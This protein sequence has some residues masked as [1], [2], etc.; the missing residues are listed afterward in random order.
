MAANRGRLARPPRRWLA[1]VIAGGLAVAA[2]LPFV[3]LSGSGHTTYYVSRDGDDRGGRSW[4]HA[5]NELD[6]IRW[7][8]VRPGDVVTIDG[9]SVA[10]P[11]DA[12]PQAGLD[13]PGARPTCGMVYRTPLVV[14]AS[15]RLGAPV[16]VALSTDP[17]H[18]GTAVV[19][20]GRTTPLPYCNQETYDQSGTELPAGIAI[21][22]RMHVVIDGR[23]RSG[24]VV[25]GA[26]TGVDLLSDRTSF[27]T[28][29][30]LEISDNGVAQRWATGW[31]SD[32]EGIAL[33][34]HDITIERSLVHDNGQDEVKDRSTGV[35]GI[36]HLPLHDIVIK[37][38]WLYNRR[39]SPLYPG[40]GFNSG[41]QAVPAQDCTH[42]DG[43]QIWG[44][45]LHQE[46]FTVE[47]TIFGPFIAQGFY[48][49]DRDRASFDDVTLTDVLFL[50]PETHGVNGDAVASDRT[51]PGNWRI[52]RV[53][54][55]LSREPLAGT[56]SHGSIDLSGSGHSLTRSIFVNGYFAVPTAFAAAS[57]NLFWGG[58]AVPGG[59]SA[60]PQF[61]GPELGTG[62]A[63][64]AALTAVVLRP[65]CA[66]C[67]GRGAT[68]AGVA[69]LLSRIDRSDAQPGSDAP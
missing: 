68:T 4:Q 62:P 69:D 34:G 52:D 45:G 37:D 2:A 3:H 25:Q 65:T 67:S 5:W 32:G 43:V 31:R 1:L 23:H 17:G 60:D 15:G 53:T 10:C 41:G 11:S 56:L 8:L 66:L 35:P 38:S 51:T 61:V 55:Y 21:R 40:Y 44:G 13:P 19:Q 30:N 59:T 12:V 16:T 57:G 33:A 39:E 18:D 7:R 64:F 36:G 27:V 58:E 9:G 50:D 26:R 49:G 20:G 6:Q 28:L 42:V 54:S 29:R 24:I 22:G 48:P 47:G 14:A 63:S 46:R